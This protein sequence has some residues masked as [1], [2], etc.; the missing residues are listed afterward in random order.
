MLVVL[1]TINFH[2]CC[3]VSA[4]TSR[5]RPLIFLNFYLK[6]FF[7]FRIHSYNKKPWICIILHGKE[8]I[9]F[10]LVVK[11]RTTISIKTHESYEIIHYCENYNNLMLWFFF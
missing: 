9:L 7:F 2:Y 5:A 11:A 6:N 3:A 10:C 1:I 8:Q 4:A